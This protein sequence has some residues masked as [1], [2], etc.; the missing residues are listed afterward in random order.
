VE[1]WKISKEVNFG[2]MFIFSFKFSKFNL[3]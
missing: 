3:S 1:K 2:L